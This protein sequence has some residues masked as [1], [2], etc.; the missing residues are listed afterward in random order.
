MTTSTDPIE[1]HTVHSERLI[2]QAEEE[3]AKGDRLQASEKAWGAV[4]HRLKVI[5]DQRGWE[6]TSHQHVYGVVR[7]I[8]NELGD[9]RIRDLFA[10]AAGLHQNYYVDAT[11]I[12]ELAYEI[13]RVKELLE[14]LKRVEMEQ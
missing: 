3:L 5:A 8:A 6:Y 2:A 4:A 10:Y 14:L 13:D 11:P 7:Q 12:E 9:Q 1:S